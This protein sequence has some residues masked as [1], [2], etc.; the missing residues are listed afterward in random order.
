MIVQFY[1]DCKYAKTSEDGVIQFELDGLPPAVDGMHFYSSVTH[2][3]RGRFYISG[4]NVG[5]I[6]PVAAGDA[7]RETIIYVSK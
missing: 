3:T 6:G 5:L 2:Q 7:Q 1:A 4:D